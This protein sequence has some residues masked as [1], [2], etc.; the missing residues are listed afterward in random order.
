MTS[1]RVALVTA[2]ARSLS[3]LRKPN[4]LD[5]VMMKA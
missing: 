4:A 2:K 5:S 1:A 3:V